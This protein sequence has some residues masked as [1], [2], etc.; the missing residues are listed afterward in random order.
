MQKRIWEPA[1]IRAHNY[2]MAILREDEAIA[3]GDIEESTIFEEPDEIEDF[4]ELCDRC[5]SL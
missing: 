4:R 3:K 1:E 2:A 5:T